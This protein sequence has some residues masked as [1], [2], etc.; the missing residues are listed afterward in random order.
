M[1]LTEYDAKCYSFRAG[2][3]GLNNQ[4][5]FQNN[6]RTFQQRSFVIFISKRRQTTLD[7]TTKN[8]KQQL[9]KNEL[10]QTTSNHDK[11]CKRNK[12]DD[13]N[14]N[15]KNHSFNEKTSNKRLINYFIKIEQSINCNS[16]RFL[17][18]KTFK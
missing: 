16:G 12:T 6:Q 7:F 5:T 14:E 18:S 2:N 4:S 9:F 3:R 17:S 8:N 1:T 11:R 15:M 13:S 10:A